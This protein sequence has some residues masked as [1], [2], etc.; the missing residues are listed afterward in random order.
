MGR[1]VDISGM[2]CGKLLVL[3][4]S[5]RHQLNSLF[6][7]RCDCG[8]EVE[9]VAADLKRGRPQ[10]CGC[11]TPALRAKAAT[12]HG[13]YYT[14]EHRIW[15]AMKARCLPSFHGS[16]HYFQ[17]G[18]RVCDR[19][20]TSFEAFIGDMGQRPSN[21][22]SIDRIDNSKGYEPGNCRWADA[23]QQMANTSATRLV[24]A[25]GVSMPIRAW[26]RAVGIPAPTI[27][28]RLKRGVFPADAVLTPGRG[29]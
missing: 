29:K 3:R 16:K 1:F 27:R 19:W 15:R 7:C 13:L 10:S 25:F 23:Y 24:E 5:R 17:K 4:F 18:I 20:L 22:H 21:R 11:L 8:S 12:T 6:W 14:P 2:R 9:C 26:A 28:G